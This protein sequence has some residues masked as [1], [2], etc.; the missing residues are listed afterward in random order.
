[1]GAGG[2]ASLTSPLGPVTSSV[3][4]RKS[5]PAGTTETSKKSSRGS[6]AVFRS[7][8]A[9]ERVPSGGIFA[10]RLG[11]AALDLPLGGRDPRQRHDIASEHTPSRRARVAR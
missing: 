2:G 7:R 8:T 3:D 1:M 4:E 5:A 10:P 6:D 9:T 11:G